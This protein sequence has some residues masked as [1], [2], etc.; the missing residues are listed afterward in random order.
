MHLVQVVWRICRSIVVA[1]ALLEAISLATAAPLRPTEDGFVL[2]I[3]P[4][5]Q[6][7]T[8]SDLRLA[9]AELARN[10][11]DVDLAVRV[12]SLAIEEGRARS[13][14]RRYGQ[15][16]AALAPW[17]TSSSVPEKVRV[18][19][20]VI[21][22]AQHEFH[23]ALSDL[24]AVLDDTPDNA[25]A[26]LTRAFVRL[27]VGD[28]AGA[29]EDC[30][31]IPQSIGLLPIAICRARVEAL[32]GSAPKAYVSLAGALDSDT[33]T[34]KAMRRFAVTV[35]AEIAAGL[36]RRDDATLLF[37]D[38]AAIDLPDVPLLAAT[39][40]HLL[41]T[42]RPAEV[43]ALL[44]GR[45]DADVLVLR[46]AI[47][48][49][50]LKDPRLAEWSGVLNERFEAARSAGVRLHL[51]EEARFRLE[52]EGDAKAALQLALE[53]WAIQKELADARL[54]LESAIA[55]G[56]PAAAGDVISAVQKSGVRDVRI[57]PLLER[58]TKTA[59]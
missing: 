7:G 15:A 1:A 25:Q 40:D 11:K 6:P 42:G 22:Q 46:K 23:A 38:A 5:D 30:S 41:E 36:G 14:P 50:L 49:K 28:L 55:A 43:L 19:R 57:M 13:D 12:A 33:Q 3:V 45:G 18:L 44:D 47:A 9:E 51:R 8:P 48:A 35:L 59:W 27:V 10:P 31:R 16:E 32:S 21:L 52:V 17:W 37:A 39:A 53:N 4:V 29:A 34:G 2:A 26:R 56:Y 24:D 58:L 20:A 54:V